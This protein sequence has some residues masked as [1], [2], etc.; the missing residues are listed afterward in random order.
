MTQSAGHLTLDELRTRTQDGSIDTVI[1]G[2]T[3]ML[4]R[5]LGKR[6]DAGYFVDEVS[7]HGAECCN[8]LIT[9]DV[10]L[11]TIDGYRVSGGIRDTAT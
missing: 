1:L 2:F 7:H 6:I 10:E 8:Y 5:L 4:G 9:V 11:N 3:D